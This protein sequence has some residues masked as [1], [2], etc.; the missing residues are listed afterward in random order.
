MI[1]SRLAITVLQHVNTAR[2]SHNTA[3]DSLPVYR[4]THVR[5]PVGDYFECRDER[6]VYRGSNPCPTNMAPH[7][8]ICKTFSKFQH[9]FG[10][11]GTVLTALVGQTE[12][13]KVNGRDIVISSTLALTATLH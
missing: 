3:N 7:N 10:R 13:T 11:L 1:T 6:N 8:G 2:I 9:H 4:N 5:P 12:T